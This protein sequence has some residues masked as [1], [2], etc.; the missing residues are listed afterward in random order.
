V[1]TPDR[2]TVCLDQPND[3]LLVPEFAHDLDLTIQ[4]LLDCLL[5]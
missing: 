5:D 1:Y 2:G 3:Q 4:D